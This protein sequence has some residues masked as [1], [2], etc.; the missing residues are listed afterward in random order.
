MLRRIRRLPSPALVIASIALILAVGGGSAAL[1]LT[2]RQSDKRIA[3]RVANKQITK[4]APGLSVN[5][6][7]SANTA[8]HANT[9]DSLNGQTIVPINTTTAGNL[10]SLN[11]LTLSCSAGV[12]TAT[13]SSGGEISA[14]GVDTITD[15]DTDNRIFHATLAAGGSVNV[16]GGTATEPDT[17]S[18]SEHIYYRGG[19]GAIIT[20]DFNALGGCNNYGSAVGG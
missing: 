12:I 11:G 16:V 2:D 13:S 19:N 5:H 10:F 15:N 8:N 4:R 7:G 20:M 17:I 14:V 9:A 1:A 18:Q 6:A 3:K